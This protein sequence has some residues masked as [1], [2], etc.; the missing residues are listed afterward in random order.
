[1]K[2]NSITGISIVEIIVASAIIGI[3]VVGITSAIQ[4]YLKIVYQNTRETQAVLLL[5]EAAE[6]LQYIRDLDYEIEIKTRDP[7]IDYSLFWNGTG[8]E[9]TDSSI[10]LPY[11]MSRT[12]RF[13]DVFRDSA[14][15]ITDVGGTLD[16][17]TK[18]AEITVEWSYSDIQK[19]ISSEI[20]IHNTY[21]N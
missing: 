10:S 7:N 16:P 13:S 14:D 20:L 6:A 21:A 3:S 11:A 4:I 2:K 9:L 19:V 15:Q 17:D 12:I 1:M 5:E 18:K 8:Y